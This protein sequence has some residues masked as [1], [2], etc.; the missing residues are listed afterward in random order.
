MAVND[1][2]LVDVLNIIENPR[3]KEDKDDG[4][5]MLKMLTKTFKEENP[6]TLLSRKNGDEKVKPPVRHV[7]SIENIRKIGLSDEV[8]NVLID[9]VFYQCHG[10]F[11][12]SHAE[13]Q[14]SNWHK[15]NLM[16][17][18]QAVKE[19]ERFLQWE[20]ER[21]KQ[22]QSESSVKVKKEKRE[23]PQKEEFS[24]YA[25]SY[26]VTL[27]EKYEFSLPIAKEIVRYSQNTNNDLIV[28]WFT[29][30]IG[31]YLHKHKPQNVESAKELLT[32]FHEKYVVPF[33]RQ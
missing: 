11:V 26:M 3:N 1:S 28:Y 25:K 12:S 9:F 18:E 4:H 6:I 10:D 29:D 13:L 30:R 19:V 17:A 27:Q 5:K 32:T 2:V 8:I 20:T 7:E 22:S 31:E 33:G 24:T 16:T 14:A 15:A 21:Q 23:E